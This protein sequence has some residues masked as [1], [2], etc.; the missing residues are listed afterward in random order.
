MTNGSDKPSTQHDT[1][2][3]ERPVPPR[4]DDPFLDDYVQESEKPDR[5]T[6]QQ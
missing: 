4:Q 2:E 3:P 1:Q 6:W 5:E